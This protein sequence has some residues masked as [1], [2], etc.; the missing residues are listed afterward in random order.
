MCFQDF[1]AQA[2]SPPTS[3]SGALLWPKVGSDA[4]KQTGVTTD[5]NILRI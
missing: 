3:I 5:E 1:Q 4:Q 2:L